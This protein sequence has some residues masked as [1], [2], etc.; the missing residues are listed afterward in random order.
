MNSIKASFKQKFLTGLIVT[1][2]IVITI[3]VLIKVFEVLDGVLSPILD[4]LLGRHITGVGF[5]MNVVLIFIVGVVSTNVFGK[6]IFSLIDR[7]LKKIP[8]FK[9]LYTGLSQITH[10]FSPHQ[11]NSFQRVVIVEYPRKGA[12]AFGFLTKAC[13]MKR[14][15]D[16]EEFC[17]KAVYIPTN[18]LYLGDIVLFKE[19]EVIDT[20]LSIEEG[21]RIF[22]SGGIALPDSLRGVKS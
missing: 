14:S 3:F 22:L 4:D 12:Y 15:P 7:I 9:G 18:N 6:K 17:L 1:V 2:P 5:I 16:D 21:I 10:A 13:S 11:K 19:D 8:I 20:A